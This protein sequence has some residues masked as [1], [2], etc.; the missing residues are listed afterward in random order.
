M[1]TKETVHV[2]KHDHLDGIYTLTFNRPNAMNALSTQMALDIISSLEE[3]RKKDDL[4]VLVITG[5]GE[6]SFCVGA[7]LKER[8]GMDQKEWHEQHRIF[9]QTAEK[10]RTFDYPII[11]ALNGYALGGGLELALSADIRMAAEHTE[12]GFP[13]AKIGII[14]GIGGTQLIPRAISVGI[15]KEI[16]FRGN[17]VNAEIAKQLGLVNHIFPS[18]NLLESTYEIAS[19][20]AR[21]AP[22]SLKMIKK[23]VDTGLQV[24]INTA[25]SI[26]LQCYYKCAD[27]EDRIE[28]IESFN[29]KRLPQ[30]KGY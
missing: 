23:A 12:V 15:A 21:N 6:K 30:W 1:E 7:D 26:E 24:D 9:E 27:S 25:L 29:E 28:G 3:L 19:E 18:S 10:I 14:P 11:A 22:I 4:R 13:E 5:S 2:S 17:R 20:I 16:L 8:K